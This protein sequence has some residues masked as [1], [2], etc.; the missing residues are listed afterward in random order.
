MVH[1]HKD[2]RGTT[3]GVREQAL[4][5][6]GR[7]LQHACQKDRRCE[8]PNP[9]H[10]VAGLIRVTGSCKL[11]CLSRSSRWTGFQMRLQSRTSA[12]NLSRDLLASSLKQLFDALCIQL[13]YQ[14]ERFLP[15]HCALR[16]PISEQIQPAVLRDIERLSLKKLPMSCLTQSQV[17]SERRSLTKAAAYD[18]TKSLK[19]HSTG[20]HALMC[21][22][23]ELR[24]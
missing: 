20:R 1:Y 16:L 24:A 23:R 18:G 10:W 6:R 2:P 7:Q 13:L 14:L 17:D 8:T 12:S 3:K 19:Y 22:D 11:R 15:W 5:H 9:S 4:A 21:Y